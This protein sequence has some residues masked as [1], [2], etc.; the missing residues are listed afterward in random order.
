MENKYRDKLIHTLETTDDDSEIDLSFNDYV[1][2]TC[3]SCFEG[4]ACK[5][6]KGHKGLHTCEHD[7]G[8]VETWNDEQEKAWM[9]E[10]K[11]WMKD[12]KK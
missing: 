6:L 3:L 10:L 7:D 2:N 8:S 12:R 9:Q 4:C 5:Q 11:D 1:K